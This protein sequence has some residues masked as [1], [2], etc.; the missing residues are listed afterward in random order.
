MELSLIPVLHPP[1]ADLPLVFNAEPGSG[2]GRVLAR[3]PRACLWVQSHGDKAW[4]G[5]RALLG[6]ALINITA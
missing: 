6:S 1:E 5:P 4:T 2:G 3:I